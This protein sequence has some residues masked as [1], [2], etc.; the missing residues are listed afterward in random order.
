MQLLLPI[1]PNDATLINESVG[2]Y[3]RDGIVQYLV[4]GLP[5]Y[6]HAK[7]ENDAFRFITSN[8]IHQSAARYN[9]AATELTKILNQTETIF[10]G[11]D[12]KM[13]FEIT[14]DLN[15]AR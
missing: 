2:V 11:T 12:L 9:Y 13:I 10:P 15:C 3:E 1:F 4:N 8:F 6:S 5:V 14:A 7:G